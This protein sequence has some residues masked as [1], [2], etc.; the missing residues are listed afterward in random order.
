[1]LE[2]GAVVIVGGTSGAGRGIAQH[3]ADRGREVVIT[4]RDANRAQAVARQIGGRTL[5]LGFDLAEPEKI[6][7]ALSGVGRVHDLILAAIERD[8][9]TVLNYDVARARRLVTLKLVGYTE[10]VHVLA[11]RLGEDGCIVL[12]GGLAKDRPYPG[13][14]TVTTVNDGISGLTRSLAREL[15]PIRV[16]A[17]HPGVQGDSPHWTDKPEALERLTSRTP[18]GRL[19]T[20]D[21]VV[22]AAVFLIEHP[23]VN[24]TSLNVDGGW[25]IT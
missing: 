9:N 19:V 17:I 11:P 2:K 23:S 13:S 16:N 4:G 1:V 14:T 6:A 25:L 10:V 12:F 8:Y 20:T 3:Y 21:E 5:G 18:L 15:A 22:S 24:S 7:A